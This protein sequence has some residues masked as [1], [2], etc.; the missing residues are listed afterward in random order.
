MAFTKVTDDLAI[1]AALSDLPNATDGLTAAQLKAKFDVAA[2]LLKTYL[3]STLTTEL[4]S[5]TAGDSGLYNIG[6]STINGYTNPQLFLQYLYNTIGGISPSPISMSRQAVINGNFDFWKDTSAT[7]PATNS[8]VANRWRTQVG[9]DGGVLPNIVISRQ[10]LTSGDIFGSYFFHRINV[11]GAGT[12]LGSGSFNI[13]LQRIENAVRYLCGS[14]KQLTL[15]F[16]AKS[17]ISNKKLGVDFSISYG[18]GG[19]PSASENIVGSNFAL[20]SSWQQFSLTITTNTIVGKTFGTNDND[21]VSLNFWPMWGSSFNSRLGAS[22][23]ETFVGSGDIDIAQVQICAGST[24]LPF[25]PRSQADESQQCDRF[26]KVFSDATNTEVPIGTGVAIS[27]TQARIVVN[28]GTPMRVSPSLTAT[29][30]DWKISDGVTSTD[31]T[32]ISIVTDQK[33]TR[34]ATLLITVAS[35]LTQ[36][37]PYYLFADTTASRQMIFDSEL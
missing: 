19:S 4:E 21:Y 11:D 2:G 32:A 36:Y 9:A 29:A 8:I 25:Q 20:T 22:S 18:T 14:G 33:S 28:L 37:R 34:T 24:A 6:M 23:A 15:T 27:T 26:M 3:N 31:V 13:L 5:T 17:S 1:I 16:Y 30:G 12:T 35:G 7:N 10:K